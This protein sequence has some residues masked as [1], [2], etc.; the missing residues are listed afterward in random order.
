M[1]TGCLRMIVNCHAA[2]SFR[3]DNCSIIPSRPYQK[4]SLAENGGFNRQKMNIKIIKANTMVIYV[5]IN[6]VS[7]WWFQT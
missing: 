3:E 2:A 6:M 4:D 7:D 5:G 1:F